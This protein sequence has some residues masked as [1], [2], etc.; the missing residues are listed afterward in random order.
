MHNLSLMEI[1][2]FIDRI[3]KWTAEP[4]AAFSLL[5]KIR[6]EELEPFIARIFEPF[7]V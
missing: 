4:L 6:P 3:L 2:A 5:L 1:E 7:T